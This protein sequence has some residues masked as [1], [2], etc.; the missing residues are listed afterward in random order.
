MN[1]IRTHPTTFPALLATALLAVVALTLPARAG[2]AT[3]KTPRIVN[4][5]TVTEIE[6]HPGDVIEL[7]EMQ[8]E[9]VGGQV[10]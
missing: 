9:F 3:A 4:G 7:G 10:Q 5:N 6:L 1:T 8:L 2:A